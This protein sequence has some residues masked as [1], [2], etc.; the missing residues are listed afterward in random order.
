M[1][2]T[3]SSALFFAPH[4]EE[5]PMRAKTHNTELFYLLPRSM[6]VGA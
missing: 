4:P 1:P 5:K 2:T 3:V 6:N